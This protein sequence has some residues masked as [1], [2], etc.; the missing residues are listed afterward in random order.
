MPSGQLTKT[1]SEGVEVT[2]FY[3]RATPLCNYYEAPFVINDQTFNSTEQYFQYM[4]ALTFGDND[5]ANYIFNTS[6]PAAQKRLGRHV[7]NY[8]E[9]K[10][11][12]SRES[13]MKVACRAKFE[14]NPELK[15]VL[16]DTG[17]SILAEATPYDKKWGTGIAIW[18]PEVAEISKWTGTNI[19]GNVLMK[20]RKYFKQAQKLS[21]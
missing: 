17:D 7:K 12:K 9:R 20:V 11:V 13:I 10:W 8:D 6:D 4:K 3:G 18:D 1:N 19:M 2:A 5:T 14:Q 15:R 16:M 21:K